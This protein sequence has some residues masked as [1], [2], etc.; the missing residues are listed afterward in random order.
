VLRRAYGGP[1]GVGCSVAELPLIGLLGSSSTLTLCA[2][3]LTVLEHLHLPIPGVWCNRQRIYGGIDE[4]RPFG[5]GMY[6]MNQEG[7]AS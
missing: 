5:E 2:G 7:S 1:G 4:S 6:P 3:A